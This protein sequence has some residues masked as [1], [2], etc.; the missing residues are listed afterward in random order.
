MENGFGQI[1]YYLSIFQ[2]ILNLPDWKNIIYSW[3][4]VCPSLVVA[5]LL[6][7]IPFGL[8][9][10]NVFGK[11]DIRKIGSGNIGAT[12]VLRTG[13]RGLAAL[14]LIFDSGKA[15]IVVW[16]SKE[17]LGPD[18][19]F[20]TSI[21]VVIGHIF[22]IWLKFHGGKGVACFF[23]VLFCLSLFSGLISIIIWLIVALIFRFSSLAALVSVFASPI[24]GYFI[25]SPK[26]GS[27]MLILALLVWIRHIKNIQYLILGKENKINLRVS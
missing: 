8:L 14:T 25:G 17:Y 1:Y 5:Y 9:I 16:L 20:F 13:R 19:T 11:E 15:I 6:G 12:N 21:F 10:T 24:L 18:I 23:G 7:S 3:H 26:I 4:I 22:P 27:I 2:I